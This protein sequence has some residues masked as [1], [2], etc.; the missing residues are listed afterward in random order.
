MRK[1]VS[2][3]GR[4][5]RWDTAGIGQT[6]NCTESDWPHP[7]AVQRSL[8][9]GIGS[10]LNGKRV[11]ACHVCNYAPPCIHT[12]T[13]KRK[14]CMYL[15][16]CRADLFATYREGCCSLRKAIHVSFLL[17]FTRNFEKPER[18]SLLL[19]R[20]RRSQLRGVMSTF[21]VHWESF[22]QAFHVRRRSY[23]NHSPE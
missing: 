1:R 19:R 20:L 11:K 17:Y 13:I 22:T 16:H 6:V 9:Q 5:K 8:W 4:W 21:H 18:R 12:L 10:E 23:S 2:V 15:I 7:F 14:A 3:A